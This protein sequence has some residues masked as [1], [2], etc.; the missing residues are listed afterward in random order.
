MSTLLANN[1]S[2]LLAAP[3]LATD[4]TLTVAAADAA[5]FPL[6]SAGDQFQLVLEDRRV[7]PNLYEVVTC[8]ARSGVL[9]T[10]T[11]AQEGT[12]ASPF[13]SGAV[14]SLR[15][16]A[17][18]VFALQA[19][20][21]ALRSA[22]DA[23]E[24]SARTAAIATETAARIA[25]DTAETAA[26]TTAITNEQA[27][28]LA[29]DNTEI[30]ARIA[31]DNTEIGARNAAIAAAISGFATA[32]SVTAEAA[33]RATGDNNVYNAVVAE[34]NRAQ[35]AEAGLA[36]AVT[37]G[38]K[39]Y[40]IAAGDYVTSNSVPFGVFPANGVALSLTIS[41]PLSSSV[42]FVF[43]SF[44]ILPDPGSDPSNPA[45]S[46]FIRRDGVAIAFNPT[47]PVVDLPGA[48][49]HTYTIEYTF[50]SGGWSFS[51]RSLACLV[52]G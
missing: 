13:Y 4:T 24:A 50:F 21:A 51:G 52:C 18:T 10:I 3:I 43:P 16:T 38:A 27:T 32:A 9:L 31:A 41:A 33:A 17:G 49:G 35:G 15:L 11:R 29:A 23:A 46:Y 44:I 12:V 19:E 7:V 40:L 1:A 47:I 36:A 14:V 30:A 39:S 5:L 25:A 28:R 42:V 22:A 20:E 34:Q 48:G 26:R 6:P 8:T 37:A 45:P 2:S